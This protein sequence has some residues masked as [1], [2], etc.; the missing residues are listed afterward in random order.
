MAHELRRYAMLRNAI[1]HEA[2]R[3][4]V[5]IA[6]PRQDVVDQIVRLRDMLL[7][8]PRL[9]DLVP[10][11]VTVATPS[12]P[13][14]VAAKR[15]FDGDFS[16]LPVVGMPEGFEPAVLTSYAIARWVTRG[17]L[18]EG[19]VSLEVAVEEVMEFDLDRHLELVDRTE[20]VLDAIAR[21][22]RYAREGRILQALVVKAE[23]GGRLV[24]I[25]TISDL[26]ALL[27]AVKPFVGTQA[28]FASPD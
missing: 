13:I 16:Q 24:A 7:T 25:A 28:F 27:A 20:T 26:P 18:E 15:M 5:P 22:D 11:G 12:L 17:L 14:G 4:G 21:F 23:P 2:R 6:D 19:G 9:V 10:R 8:A 3:G 1:S